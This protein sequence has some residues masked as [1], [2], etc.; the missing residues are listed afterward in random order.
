MSTERLPPGLTP[1]HHHAARDFDLLRQ[2]L[3]PNFPVERERQLL[4]ALA[5]FARAL[6]IDPHSPDWLAATLFSMALEHPDLPIIKRR[7]GGIK[8]ITDARTLL[9]TILRLKAML[10]EHQNRDVTYS[11]VAMKHLQLMRAPSPERFAEVDTESDD[12]HKAH[13][14]LRDRISKLLK[15]HPDLKEKYAKKDGVRVHVELGVR[16]PD[17]LLNEHLVGDL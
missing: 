7:K 12:F 4:Q 17:P 5:N 15:A 1:V 2:V 11:Y 10:E 3:P 9:E 14:K 8:K 16:I 6:E 13:K